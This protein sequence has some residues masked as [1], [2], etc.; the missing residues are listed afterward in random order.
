MGELI[1]FTGDTDNV[2]AHIRNAFG[3]PDSNTDLSSGVGTSYPIVSIKGKVFHVARGDERTLITNDD[4]DAKGS[5]E[6]VILQANP[7][8]SKV[9][10]PGGYVEG[11]EEKP[12]CYSNSGKEPGADAQ[13]PQSAKC[14]TCPHNAWGS[15]ITENGAKGKA[16]SD[17]RRLAIASIHDLEDPMLMRVPAAT[18]KELTAYADLLTKRKVPYKAVVTKISF[19]HS[20][21][22]PKLVFKPVRFLSDIEADVVIG[23]LERSVITEITGMAPAQETL[24]IAG[25]PPAKLMDQSKPKPTAVKKHTATEAEVEEALEPKK[26][27]KTEPAPAPKPKAEQKP[28]AAPKVVD[29]DEESLDD[30]LAGLENDD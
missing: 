4:G 13:D 21:A 17:S 14:A 23:V 2:P 7:G 1:L 12:T 25:T 6:V 11:S 30:I 29:A 9:Y 8:I 27:E 19:D 10:Y 24:E 3:T 20:V 22:H 26:A 18:L 28:K 16:C 15:R 5:I